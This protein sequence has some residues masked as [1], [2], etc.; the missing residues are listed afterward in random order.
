MYLRY[1]DYGGDLRRIVSSE[2]TSCFEHQQR[3][4]HFSAQQQMPSADNK[5]NLQHTTLSEF[6]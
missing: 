2:C 4:L 5:I 3:Y 1:L 6:V